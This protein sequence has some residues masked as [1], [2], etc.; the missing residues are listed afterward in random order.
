MA[1][2]IIHIEVFLCG[3]ESPLSSQYKCV[4]MMNQQEGLIYHQALC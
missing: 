1:I 4:I 3:S 2:Q